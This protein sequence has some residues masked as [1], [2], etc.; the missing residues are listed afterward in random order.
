[1]GTAGPHGLRAWVTRAE[2]T[3]VC[4][5]FSFM[6]SQGLLGSI[7]PPAS[8]FWAIICLDGAQQTHV[9][10]GVGR[11]G[12][13]LTGGFVT[14]PLPADPLRGR[15]T[16]M[17]A[18]SSSCNLDS[19]PGSGPSW[20]SELSCIFLPLWASVDSSNKWGLDAY[21]DCEA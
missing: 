17:L 19:H 6:S 1:M 3:H 18:L 15:G 14:S 12:V 9:G 10:W 7:P 4:F 20:L 8:V 16:G 21:S 2:A 11:Q 5:K 13:G